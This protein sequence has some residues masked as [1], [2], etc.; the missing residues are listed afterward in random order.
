MENATQTRG[1]VL[2]KVRFIYS[3]IIH[4][5]SPKDEQR[6]LQ[7]NETGAV[8][9]TDTRTTVLDGLVGQG[10]LAQVVTDH[11]GLDLHLWMG[12]NGVLVVWI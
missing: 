2:I 10:E 6:S 12:E 8:G 7:R 1:C 5:N 11:L 3:R 4:L 9:G